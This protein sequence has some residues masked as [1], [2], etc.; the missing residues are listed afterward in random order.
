MMRV[1][2]AGGSRVGAADGGGWVHPRWAKG[3][4]EGVR[5]SERGVEFGGR[6]VMF[7]RRFF[8]SGE[9]MWKVG[10]LGL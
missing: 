6:W 5:R 10:C 7:G 2:G 1:G 4:G 9:G 8:F 3:G